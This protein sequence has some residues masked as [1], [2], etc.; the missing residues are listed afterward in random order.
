MKT[1][2]PYILALLGFFLPVFCYW[3][4]GHDFPFRRGPDLAGIVFISPLLALASFCIG[5]VVTI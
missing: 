5:K 1:A 2:L 3:V 4:A